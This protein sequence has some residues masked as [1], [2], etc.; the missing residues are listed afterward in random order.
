MPPSPLSDPILVVEPDNL[1]RDLMRRQLQNAGYS[2][3]GRATGQEAL[4]RVREERL[5]ALLV[6]L[7]LPDVDG[8]T[9][10]RAARQ[11]PLNADVPILMVSARDTEADRILSF[12]NG[13]DDC[14]RKPFAAR[15]LLARVHAIV[16]R[17]R[18]ASAP[19]PDVVEVADHDLI[20]DFPARQLY[21]RGHRVGLT[22]QEFDLLALLVSK[23]GVVF[24]RAAIV[25]KLWHH[26]P[27][28]SERTVDSIVR[29]VRRKIEQVPEQPVL[30]L[31]SWGVGYKFTDTT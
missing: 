20:V 19:P 13:A 23:R 10:C 3:E 17:H 2:A 5:S 14:L 7:L 30:L 8:V 24:S 16:R 25:T 18:A 4:A 31:T 9:I 29:R 28:I 27:D 15:E 6:D 12:D 11:S 22:K 21:V 26:D 1:I